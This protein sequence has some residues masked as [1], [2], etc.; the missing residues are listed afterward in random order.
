MVEDLKRSV[1]GKDG[2]SVIRGSPLCRDWNGI[3][4]KTGL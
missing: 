3:H 1:E 2:I 4:Y